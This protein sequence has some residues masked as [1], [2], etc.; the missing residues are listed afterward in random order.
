MECN[1]GMFL[2]QCNS[3]RIAYCRKQNE[4]FCQLLQLQNKGV[5]DASISNRYSTLW[6]TSRI[7]IIM[8][9]YN[10]IIRLFLFS[11]FCESYFIFLSNFY[12]KICKNQRVVLEF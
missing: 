4:K 5:V 10:V 9:I 3:D 8:I 11:F 12:V 1:V 7:I 6:A 2:V